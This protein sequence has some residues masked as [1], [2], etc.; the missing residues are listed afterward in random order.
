M[1]SDGFDSALFLVKFH[2]IFEKTADVGI[3]RCLGCFYILTLN[4]GPGLTYFALMAKLDPSRSGV[5]VTRKPSSPHYKVMLGAVFFL[6][7]KPDCS[8]AVHSRKTTGA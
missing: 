5:V 7:P 3:L 1:L 4:A 6:H 8:P 2:D